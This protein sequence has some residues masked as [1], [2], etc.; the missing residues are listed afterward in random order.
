[1][2][3]IRVM[4]ADDHPMFRE[5]VRR[6]LEEQPDIEVVGEAS[7]GK[8]AIT[9]A[10][11]L[12]PDVLLL[13]VAMPEMRGIEVARKLSSELP[14]TKL[15]ALTV[16][17]D[18][19]CARRFIQAGGFGFI[20]KRAGG[21]EISTAIRRV[22]AGHVHIFADQASQLWHDILSDKVVPPQKQGKLSKRE[23]QI[24]A[25][26]AQGYTNQRIADSLCISHRTV[27]THR[28]RITAKLGLKNRA[29]L[30]RYA[31]ENNLIPNADDE[32]ML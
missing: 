21:T 12:K 30:V 22:H 16:Y 28:T 15:V 27:E 19:E 25:L 32:F 20:V 26:I 1:M 23:T 18:A 9:M 6:S 7:D 31:L 10:H 24:L 11:K 5:G 2:H 29:Q 8:E 13:D 17:D 3:K 14:G 4:L